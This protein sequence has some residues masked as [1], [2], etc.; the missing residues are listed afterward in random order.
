MYYISLWISTTFPT[1]PISGPDWQARRERCPDSPAG[2]NPRVVEPM[3]L[4]EGSQ[5]LG[6]EARREVMPIWV[7][8][9]VEPHAD[10]LGRDI[11][12][13][14]TALVSQLLFL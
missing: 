7:V 2:A 8:L 12:V 14:H 6:R 13:R 11:D 4:I 1:K 5:F 9:I 3:K 10:Q